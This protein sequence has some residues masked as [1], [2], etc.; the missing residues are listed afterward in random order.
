MG[1]LTKGGEVARGVSTEHRAKR[2]LVE[3]IKSLCS[4]NH[5]LIIPTKVIFRMQHCRWQMRK[6]VLTKC[7]PIKCCN[8]NLNPEQTLTTRSIK[9]ILHGVTTA[10][11]YVYWRTTRLARIGKSKCPWGPPP[12]TFSSLNSLSRKKPWSHP[13]YHRHKSHLELVLRNTL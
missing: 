4:H 2:P 12:R 5:L 11:L 10:D 3:T 7:K 6:K 8:Y 1:R 13:N 9:P